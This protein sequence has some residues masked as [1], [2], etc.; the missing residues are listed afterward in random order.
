MLSWKASMWETSIFCNTRVSKICCIPKDFPLTCL[1]A[2]TNWIIIKLFEVCFES[3]LE[4]PKWG[5]Q[6][7]DLLSNCPGHRVQNP[8]LAT[9]PMAAVFGILRHFMWVI[10]NQPSAGNDI[11]WHGSLE[12]TRGR[13][14]LRQRNFYPAVPNAPF[15]WTFWTPTVTCHSV[16][17]A[18]LKRGK[19]KTKNLPFTMLFLSSVIHEW[20]VMFQ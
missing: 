14:A 4:Q 1:E 12:H 20:M 16:I 9:T 6:I 7:T 11:W 13:G 19:K 15:L 5:L 3:T 8:H 18:I 2:E 10:Q 17:K